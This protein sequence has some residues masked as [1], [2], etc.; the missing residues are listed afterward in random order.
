MTDH[1]QASRPDHRRLRHAV[2]ELTLQTQ[3]YVAKAAH[4]HG[5]H[6]ADVH[7]VGLIRAATDDRVPTSPGDLGRALALSPAAVTAM[8]D[9]MERSGHVRRSRSDRD[10]RR[11]EAV[12]TDHAHR[13]S[14]ELFSPLVLAYDEILRRYTDDEVALVARV[15]EELRA[16]T[17]AVS[18]GAERPGPQ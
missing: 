16:A 15:L 14:D 1:S 11:V 10:A 17:A 3:A 6:D 4:L 13:T 8:L 18:P 7:A 2:R 9:R 12:L 5:M